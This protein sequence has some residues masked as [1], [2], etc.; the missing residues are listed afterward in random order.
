MAEGRNEEKQNGIL[1]VSISWFRRIVYSRGAGNIL[2]D[3]SL[4][5]SN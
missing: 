2:L 5:R 1:T 4:T 3:S